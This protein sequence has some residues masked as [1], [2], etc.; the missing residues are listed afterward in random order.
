MSGPHDSAEGAP[1]VRFRVLRVHADR[2]PAA[3]PPWHGPGG[4]WTFLDCALEGAPAATFSL[5]FRYEGRGDALTWGE[6]AIAATSREAGAAVLARLAAAFGASVP[7]PSPERPLALRRY[8]LVVEEAPPR[9]APG[10]IRSAWLVVDASASTRMRVDVELAS[11]RGALVQPWHELYTPHLL[12]SLAIGLRDGPR[13]AATPA[14]DPR[15][16]TAGPRIEGWRSFGSR[17]ALAYGFRGGHYVLVEPL[18]SGR[19]VKVVDLERGE[20]R[21]LTRLAGR[22]GDV[23]FGGA[24]PDRWLVAEAEAT[25]DDYELCSGDPMRFWWLEDGARRELVGEWSPAAAMLAHDAIAPGADFAAII[26]HEELP[27]REDAT[28]V[29]HLV[30]LASGTARAVDPESGG[31]DVVGWEAGPPTRAVL[32][33]GFLWD[34]DG[35]RERVVADPVT[36]A[37]SRCTP[38]T[39]PGLVSPGGRWSAELAGDRILVHDL[40]G[41]PVRAFPLRPE[42]AEHPEHRCGWADPRYLVLV[43]DRFALID[44]ETLKMSYLTEPGDV[45]DYV[46][47]PDFRWMAHRVNDFG[48]RIGRVVRP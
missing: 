17:H 43:T 30:D 6:G 15:L 10:A 3:A 14:T 40:R 5:G 48:I 36:G 13:P 37:W 32:R 22:A 19:V 16:A 31:T 39:A 35:G 29:V 25:S 24:A 41:G 26:S 2:A 8:E 1:R 33:R 23:R 12:R 27:G 45:P 28:P 42:E 46:G 7:G 44:A 47:S 34:P 9:G 20:V 4:A 21:E 18:G 11:G 38:P